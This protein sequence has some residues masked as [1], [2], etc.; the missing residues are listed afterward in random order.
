M[1][2]EESSKRIKIS[3]YFFF[4]LNQIENKLNEK[5]KELENFINKYGPAGYKIDLSFKIISVQENKINNSAEILFSDFEEK[6]NNLNLEIKKIREFYYKNQSIAFK[7]VFKV[8]NFIEQCMLLCLFLL[9]FEKSYIKQKLKIKTNKDFDS[10][11]N[12]A[13]ISFSAILE[14]EFNEFK[15]NGIVKR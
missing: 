14:S 7:L 10:V 4:R 3:K 13:L 12:N 8:K 6:I 1:T 11:L 5:V 2:K 15:K 9:K